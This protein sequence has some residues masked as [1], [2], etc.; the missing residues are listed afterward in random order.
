MSYRRGGDIGGTIKGFLFLVFICVLI[1]AFVLRFLGLGHPSG[2]VVFG[3]GA[4][5]LAAAVG[6]IVVVVRMASLVRANRERWAPCPHGV[7]GGDQQSL[8][9]T[10]VEAKRLADESAKRQ[11]EEQAR[12]RQIDASAVDLKRRETARLKQS[13]SLT[14]DELRGLTPQRFEDEIA[15]MF[16][17]LGYQVEQ[18]PYSNDMGRDAVMWKDG[19]KF[20]LECKRYA[21]DGLSGRPELQKFHSAIMNDH[22]KKGFFVSTGMFTKAAVDYATRIPVE[23][24]DGR[25]LARVMLETNQS[26]STD[27]CYQSVC[28]K[29][30]SS[31]N[32]CLRVPE[33]VLCGC[34]NL[35]EATLTLD[36]VLGATSAPTCVKCGAPMRVVSR[37]NGKFWGCSRYPMCRSSKP[38]VAATRRR[39]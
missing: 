35:V 11:Q 8:C 22:A 32:H 36:D 25:K 17:R 23:I 3:A 16:R 1:G 24:I 15:S 4:A 27:D 2:I 31:I 28:R 19:D 29:C 21:E 34:G 6:L 33:A 10:C 20:L 5:T 7:R 26:A 38:F 39:A 37:R 9:A 18:T 12:R 30:G 14:L 13:I